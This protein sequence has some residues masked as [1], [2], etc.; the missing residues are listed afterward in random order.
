[1]EF[2]FATATQIIFG[3]HR[4]RELPALATATGGQRALVVTGQDQRRQEPLR[5]ALE[6]AKITTSSFAVPSEPTIELA[7]QATD[8]ARAARCDLVVAIGG[9]SALDLGKAVAALAV[10]DGDVMDFVEVIGRGMALTQRPLPFLALPTTAGTGSEVTRNA[11]LASPEHRVKVSLRSASMLPCLALVDPELTH[12]MPPAVTASTGLDAL[13]QLL[14]PFVSAGANPLTDG[15][16]REGLQRAARSLVPAYQDG[17]NADARHDMAL[18]SLFGGLALANAK[19][20]AVHGCA[21]PVGGMFGAPHGAVCARLLGPAM[22]ANV[23]A[24]Q[25]R[26]PENPAIARYDEVAR[27]VTG[28]PTAT[29]ADGVAWV[30][31]LCSVLAV[32]TLAD[33]GMEAA[34]MPSVVPKAQAASSMAGNPIRLTDDELTALLTQ[35][36]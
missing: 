36:L 32:P 5:Q 12:D 16:C 26:E 6:R 17:H 24:L 35:A 34:D 3:P 27:L 29:A 18:A 4:S 8:Q 7:R 9:G 23:Q 31:E 30:E 22:A 10:N 14:E 33:Y 21:A 1:M 25:I 19:L 28:R 13:T 2:Q 11:V 15:L 20:G